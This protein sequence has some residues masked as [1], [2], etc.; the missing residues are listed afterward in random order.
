MSSE[1]TVLHVDDEPGLTDVAAS[2]LERRDERFVVEMAT[3]ADEGLDLLDVAVYEDG[4]EGFVI[5]TDLAAR[6]E[7][8]R[9][10]E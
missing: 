1:I 8:E 4:S 6:T 2:F 7:R 3:S 10:A 9:G 5:Y